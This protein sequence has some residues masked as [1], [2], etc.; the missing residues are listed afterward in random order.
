MNGY[1]ISEPLYESHRSVIYRGVRNEDNANVILKVLNRDHVAPDQLAQFRMEYAVTRELDV[2]G[3]ITALAIEPYGNRIMIVYDDILGRS[4][5]VHM[6]ERGG[7]FT[8]RDFLPVATSIAH[9]L[10]RVHDKEFIHKNITP[11]NIIWEPESD[12]LQFI[13]FGISTALSKETQAPRNPRVIEGSLPYMSPEQTGRMNRAMDY[14]TD[15]YSLGVTFYQMLAGKPPFETDDPVEMVHC[16]IAREPVPLHALDPDIPEMLSAIVMKLLSKMAEDRYQSAAGLAKDLSRCLDEM[17]EG[18]T[19]PRFELDD[20]GAKGQF[21][22]PQKYYGRRKEI[23]LLMEGFYRASRGN[24]E[25]M[26]VAGYSGIG[27]SSLVKEIYKPIVQEKGYYLSGKFDQYQHDKPHAPIIQACSM[28]ISYLLQESDEQQARWRK[29]LKEALRDEAQVL[30]D[31][32]PE[33]EELIGPQP[34]PLELTGVEALA[35][36]HKLFV[37][38]LK[39][40]GSAG[41]PLTLFLDDLQWVDPAS[42][43]LLKAIMSHRSQSRHL[44]VIGAYRD[45]EVSA[46]HPL[47]HALDE[48]EENTPPETRITTITISP[49]SLMDTQ[50][51]LADTLNCS[52]ESVVP[53]A[54]VIQQKTA[55]NPF[56]IKQLLTNLHETGKVQYSPEH[57]RWTWSEDIATIAVCDNVGDI[58]S[59][60]IATLPKQTRNLLGLASCLGTQFDLNTLAIISRRPKTEIADGLWKAVTE[61]LIAPQDLACSFFRLSTSDEEID[62][63]GQG[64]YAFSH[65]RIQE[66]AYR[67]L[68]T[69]ERTQAHLEAGRLLLDN[70]QGEPSDDGLFDIVNHLNFS[71]ALLEDTDEIERLAFLNL[72]AGLSAKKS[73][74]YSAARDYFSKG[75]ELLDEKHWSS[76]PE[77]MFQLYRN[78]IETEFLCG[79]TQRA[80]VMFDHAVGCIRNKRHKGQLYELMVRICQNDYA[81][82]R[83][84]ELGKLG[85]Q[86]FDIVIPE[87]PDAYT[88]V[89]KAIQ[90]EISEHIGS[91][92]TIRQLADGPSMTD[93]D[94]IVCC[95]ILHELWVCLFMS[96]NP[97]MVFPAIKLIQLSIAYG[98]SAVTAVGY[99]FYALIQTMQRNYDDAYTL[100]KLAM[101]LKDKHLDPLHAPKVLNTFCNFVNHYKHHVGSNIPLYEQS[102]RFCLQSGEIWWGAWAASFIRNA[103]LIKGDPLNQVKK[104]GEQYADYIR[105]A[106]FAPLVHIMNAQMAKITNL[107]GETGTRTS[108]DTPNF[109]EKE[110]IDILAAMPFNVGLFWHNV[111]KT[112][113]YYLYGEQELA[114]EAALSAEALKEHDPGL[115]QFPDHFFFSTLVLVDTW[116]SFTGKEKVEYG[117]LIERNIT[118]METWQRHCPDNFLHRYLLMRAEWERIT[119]KGHSASNHYTEAIDAARRNGFIHHEAI[120]NELT[121]R[122]LKDRDKG[123]EARPYLLEA[124]LLFLQWNAKRK[125]TIFDETHPG[126]V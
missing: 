91:G 68:S 34:D 12:Q 115:M 57:K 51:L 49:L 59:Q 64:R 28:L 39:T 60:K 113:L 109:N 77:I 56:F 101:T 23:D 122:F 124:R 3:V 52:V 105:E 86:L 26:L 83:G 90:L 11:S 44:L 110:T 119:G 88:A 50:T 61:E 107:M 71:V 41:H 36:F 9:I 38:L 47:M 27:K 40:F 29:R 4:I 85:L 65:D 93:E 31:V 42:L 30:I 99:I 70:A 97:Q 66:A 46:S 106:E 116:D 73:T 74:A 114:L 19:I 72:R 103:R 25:L 55:G 45:N 21:R 54:A 126:L 48:M 125:V 33:L 123:K 58:L 10:K 37:K 92:E 94:A 95:G 43:G 2:D 100:G 17:G 121:G 87:E 6:K 120:A 5:D 1:H 20:D 98:Q 8:V 108:I 35:R 112:L 111:S 81:Y 18:N 53:L 82:D 89:C 79:N 62:G 14:R 96:E 104:V 69:S 102:Y 80:D 117:K 118:M 84:I 32:L 16:H 76:H 78:G 63:L 24:V 15:L 22:I 13:D 67:L 7:K 75:I